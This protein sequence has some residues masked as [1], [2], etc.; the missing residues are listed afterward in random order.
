[1]D[2]V[3]VMTVLLILKSFENNLEEE[4]KIKLLRQFTNIKYLLQIKILVFA[5][6]NNFGINQ[7]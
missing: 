6:Y 1:M 3:V 5:I 2:C 4:S 7:D